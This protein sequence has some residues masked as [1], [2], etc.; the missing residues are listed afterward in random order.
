MRFREHEE[1]YDPVDPL[2]RID[3]KPSRVGAL[4]YTSPETS[5]LTRGRDVKEVSV[6][7]NRVSPLDFGS[8]D[9]AMLINPSL[10]AIS[11]FR[12]RASDSAS[13]EGGFAKCALRTMGDEQVHQCN[14]AVP[15]PL[16]PLNEI[17]HEKMESS[18]VVDRFP[19]SSMLPSFQEFDPMAA[20]GRM[21][22]DP[23]AL[24]PPMEDP[25][26]MDTPRVEKKRERGLESD[27]LAM[28]PSV[29]LVKRGIECAYVDDHQAGTPWTVSKKQSPQH[30]SHD[31][32]APS[33]VDE[34]FIAIPLI[35][36]MNGAGSSL[37]SR[38]GSFSS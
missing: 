26:L 25:F 32:N 35:S 17:I 31:V 7:P 11:H 27:F 18:P 20:Q 29:P 12:K 5:I 6:V 3:A 36:P 2:P 34:L 22:Q 28:R 24:F 13:T 37:H 8:S 10:C 30:L 33:W 14:S 23:Q 1:K 21:P 15:R 38:T 9:I 16:S 19:K 4:P